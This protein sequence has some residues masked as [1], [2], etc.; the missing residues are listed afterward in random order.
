M[1]VVVFIFIGCIMLLVREVDDN[2][3]VIDAIEFESIKHFYIVWLSL[4]CL[5]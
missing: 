1:K 3:N 4:R 5:V 2:G